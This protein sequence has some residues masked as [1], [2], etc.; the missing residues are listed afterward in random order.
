MSEGKTDRVCTLI[1]TA[2][3]H[4]A[5]KLCQQIHANHSHSYAGILRL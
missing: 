1:Y 3:T 2:H 5:F 4:S